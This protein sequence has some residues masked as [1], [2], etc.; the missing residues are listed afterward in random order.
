MRQTGLPEFR[1]ADLTRDRDLIEKAREAG[2]RIVEKDGDLAEHRWLRDQ[3]A[4]LEDS[5][6][7]IAEAG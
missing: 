1:Y 6:F 4:G 5:G 2:D 3:I 7:L